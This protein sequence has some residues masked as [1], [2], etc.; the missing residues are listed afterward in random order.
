MDPGDAK[1]LKCRRPPCR[2]ESLRVLNESRMDVSTLAEHC[3]SAIDV[4]GACGERDWG[5]GGGV[6]S[7]YRVSY[8]S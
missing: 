1:P 2:R 6:A 3:P 4:S 5:A 7:R 8:R